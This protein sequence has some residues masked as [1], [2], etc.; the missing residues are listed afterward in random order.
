MKI[1]SGLEYYMDTFDFFNLYQYLEKYF[2]LDKF[3]QYL[4]ISRL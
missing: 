4:P 2:V 3:S 1:T